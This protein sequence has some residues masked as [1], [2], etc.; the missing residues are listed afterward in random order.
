MTSAQATAMR[1]ASE[2]E[3]ALTA[4][5]SASKA[6]LQAI[7]NS[8]RGEDSTV[9]GKYADLNSI[10]ISFDTTN[11]FGMSDTGQAVAA[12]NGRNLYN[13]IYGQ[14]RN[15]V[16]DQCNDASLQRAVTAYLMAVEQDCNTVQTSL[17]ENRKKMKSAI[18]EGSAMLDLARVENRQKH[19]ADDMTTCLNNVTAAIQSEEVCGKNYKKC[20]D[21]G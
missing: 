20:L 11:A 21:N 9:G 16:R 18:R 1:K 13:A 3:N 10:N 8:I 5:G 4:D 7:I 14:C 15:A 2:G 6:L 12:Y 17:E 19:N